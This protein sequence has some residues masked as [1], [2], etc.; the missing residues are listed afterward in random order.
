MRERRAVEEPVLVAVQVV[1]DV[2]AAR[3]SLLDVI[4][5]DG[6]KGRVSASCRKV[7]TSI[8][9]PHQD[10]DS[11]RPVVE[12]GWLAFAIQPAAL[13]RYCFASLAWPRRWC[14]IAMESQ[15]Q[16]RWR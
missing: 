1:A 5:A 11:D 3:A 10:Q 8:R 4:L 16:A 6:R 7:S 13:S 9:S 14:A 12:G 2:V 15:S